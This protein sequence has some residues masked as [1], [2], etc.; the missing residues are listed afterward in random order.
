MTQATDPPP[1]HVVERTEQIHSA[2]VVPDR[3]HAPA[4]V[5]AGVDVD[6]VLPETGVIRRERD[7]AASGQ[8]VGIAQVG[9]APEA[10]G[11]VLAD[12]G[13]LV[14]AEDGGALPF[15]AERQQ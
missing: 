3:L 4:G 11:L 9:R 12:P 2:D 5:P 8:L 14:E 7:V 1:V 13:G 6:P 10:D 15:R